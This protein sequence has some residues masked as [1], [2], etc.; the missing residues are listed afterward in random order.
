MDPVVL[1]RYPGLRA[2]QSDLFRRFL[3]ARGAEFQRFA[4]RVPV[5]PVPGPS[6]AGADFLDPVLEVVFRPRVT[7]LGQSGP[8]FW[9]ISIQQA[10]NPSALGEV[11]MWREALPLEFPAIRSVVPAILTAQD[12]PNLRAAADAAGALFL[13]VNSTP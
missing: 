3:R 11:L 6:D 10:A 12:N 13:T 4:F 9:A 1:D 2:G 7:V 8:V 5:G